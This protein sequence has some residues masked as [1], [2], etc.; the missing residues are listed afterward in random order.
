MILQNLKLKRIAAYCNI[1]IEL[2]NFGYSLLKLVTKSKF[3]KSIKE[4]IMHKIEYQCGIIKK[5]TCNLPNTDDKDFEMLLKTNHPVEK[6]LSIIDKVA[7]EENL[8]WLPASNYFLLPS[9]RIKTINSKRKYV[10]NKTISSLILEN[11][12]ELLNT[13][14]PWPKI[15]CLNVTK[16]KL[17]NKFKREIKLTE[18]LKGI[19]YELYLIVA[20]K[21][22][23]VEFIQ[24]ETIRENSFVSDSSI[25]FNSNF[26][27]P[28][29]KIRYLFYKK[30]L[31]IP[32]L[33]SL[34]QVLNTFWMNLFLIDDFFL[35]V[36]KI[37][38]SI[39][40]L[41]FLKITFIKLEKYRNNIR[42][43]LKIDSS[44]TIT[45]NYIEDDYIFITNSNFNDMTELFLQKTDIFTGVENLDYFTIF[46][47]VFE[48]IHF[49]K[50]LKYTNCSCLVCEYLNHF[51]NTQMHYNQII[52]L[53]LDPFSNYT[54]FFNKA[55]TI[56]PPIFFVDEKNKH[57]NYKQ[58]NAK[59]FQNYIHIKILLDSEFKKIN[60][61]YSK[62]LI[63][64]MN[65]LPFDV[66]D[67]VDTLNQLEFLDEK[68]NSI[69]YELRS[70][71]YECISQKSLVTII[72]LENVW[73]KT[74]PKD[75][76][77]SKSLLSLLPPSFCKMKIILIYNKTNSL[78]TKSVF[79]QKVI[80]QKC[81]IRCDSN[82]DSSL[83]F[84]NTSIQSLL[85]LKSFKNRMAS[86][87]IIND[88]NLLPISTI[89]WVAEL[90]SIAK[91]ELRNNGQGTN[92]QVTNIFRKYFIEDQKYYTFLV[93]EYGKTADF[94]EFLLN[95]IH[96]LRCETIN[97]CPA[98]DNF[99]I[100]GKIINSSSKIQKCYKK[101]SIIQT[102]GSSIDLENQTLST[103][104]STCNN[105]DLKNPPKNLFI[106][107]KSEG[108]TFPTNKSYIKSY[109]LKNKTIYYKNNGISY[110]Y[111]LNSILLNGNGEFKSL[112]YSQTHQ[113]WMLIC[114]T[115]LKPFYIT[116]EDILFDKP[117]FIPEG[118][119]YTK[120]LQDS[121]ITS[122][123]S[124]LFI[125]LSPSIP[126]VYSMNKV[127]NSDIFYNDVL[128]YINLIRNSYDD[129][130]T[131]PEI[132]N[133]ILLAFKGIE[134]IESSEN[135]FADFVQ[136]CHNRNKDYKCISICE[137]VACS[138]FC[139]KIEK[140][141]EFANSKYFRKIGTSILAKNI[142]NQMNPLTKMFENSA[143]IKRT[144]NKAFCSN[145][146]IIVKKCPSVLVFDL[147]CLVSANDLCNMQEF[148]IE[149][150]YIIAKSKTEGRVI[151]SLNSVILSE[152]HDSTQKVCIWC[153]PDWEIYEN[154]KLTTK[155]KN[156]SDLYSKGYYS[157]LVFYSK[158]Q[159]QYITI[160][161]KFLY[162]AGSF[163]NDLKNNLSQNS[164]WISSLS[165]ILETE[166]NI[167]I[168]DY[169]FKFEKCFNETY[170]KNE[171][172]IK[173]L[174]LDVYDVEHVIYVILNRLHN[175]SLCSDEK[176]CPS[177]KNFLI[178]G[179]YFMI[180][181]E[182]DNYNKLNSGKK[183]SSLRM[184]KLENWVTKKNKKIEGNCAALVKGNDGEFYKFEFDELPEMI[185]YTLRY[186]VEN[187]MNSNDVKEMCL[188][189][190]KDNIEIKIQAKKD[191]Q[192]YIIHTIVMHI[193]NKKDKYLFVRH[194]TENSMWQL[195]NT[196]FPNI[197]VVL[198]ALKRFQ[199]HDEYF[200]ALLLYR[201]YEYKD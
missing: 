77:S 115:G 152:F 59:T 38:S 6:I 24:E 1:C 162:H 175:E 90:I 18:G 37:K 73:Y 146:E 27:D 105:F 132:S 127:K 89:Q 101:Y 4:S 25:L 94:V 36:M 171:G 22:C 80:T 167:I 2:D 74:D 149:N 139:S 61:P 174:D 69:Y 92:V 128:K 62:Y 141:I 65:G 192:I 135:I 168:Q 145:S 48:E 150:E 185:W 107:F 140:N 70:I 83:W 87:S 180:P 104:K 129:L 17:N 63:F 133:E 201:K 11:N 79:N 179:K 164:K 43:N 189:N 13:Y 45:K 112:I 114:D 183:L 30:S 137:C 71:I 19:K 84:I 196:L 66:F 12:S 78:I 131:P 160:A 163:K 8:K 98:C 21:K 187:G 188:R 190:I 165:I 100:E 194:I 53:D 51:K 111:Q 40:F 138:V 76:Q 182:G 29:L 143:F 5:I 31:E 72:N 46:E 186:D 55:K 47:K 154:G 198:E 57:D 41:K 110:T 193:K 9:F 118:L 93:K 33:E 158:H 126:F 64:K 44:E 39:S 155:I 153:F 181:I 95:T 88:M 7:E 178:K 177:C 121:I 32:K 136:I 200:P 109:I 197:N 113:K 199:E 67:A 16:V 75:F 23:D 130:E 169:L 151:F 108:N 117:G 191:E 159:Y 123:I 176:L 50:S 147:L 3:V 10:A 124:S 122:Y 173:N 172:K 85:N 52:S 195:N 119:I 156:I 20:E 184:I 26:M 116:L 148:P 134:D 170:E 86:F 166:K 68:N 35:A 15:L 34:K 81:Q 125:A 99:L 58:I 14:E 91:A 157:T 96:K 142:Q 120:V 49:F 144:T 106:A 103:Y 82:D 97:L 102:I 54:D 60:F 42:E 28:N 161:L 56:F